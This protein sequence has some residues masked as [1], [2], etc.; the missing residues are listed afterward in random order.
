MS[1]LSYP[2]T[3]DIHFDICPDL[4]QLKVIDEVIFNKIVIILALALFCFLICLFVDFCDIG[5]TCMDV[6]AQEI[7]L[8]FL[9]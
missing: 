6:Y 9:F 8:V 1:V 2:C 5:Q 4:V 3:S 7:Y